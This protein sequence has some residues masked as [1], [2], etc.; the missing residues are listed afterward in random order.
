MKSKISLA[1]FLWF[2]TLTAQAAVAIRNLPDFS[3]L[4]DANGASVVN[5]STTQAVKQAPMPQGAPE[6]PDGSPFND[7][8]RRYFG[9][10]GVPEIDTKSLGSGF[11]I[12]PDGFVLTAAHVVENAKEVVV[13]LTD[14]REFSASVVGA[15]RRSDV[16]LL[17]IAAT[18]LPAVTI[19]DPA[20]LKVGEWV[21]AIGAPFGFESSATSGIVSAKGRSLPTENYVPFIQTDVAINPGNSG[22]PLFNLNGEVVGINSQIYSRTGGFMGLSFAVPIDMAMNIAQQLKTA[23]RVKRGWLGVTIQDVTRELAQSFGM[24][25]PYGALI[26]DILPNSPASKSELRVGDVVV[27]YEGKRIDLSSELPP[28]VG[29]TEAGSRVKLGVMR[30]GQYRTVHVRVGELPDEAATTRPTSTEP[31]TGKNQLGLA[32]NELTPQQKKQLDL[33]HGVVV[34]EIG[35][36]PALHAGIRPG[37]VIVEV[38]GKPIKNIAAFDQALKQAPKDRPVAV[39]VRRG[40]GSLFLALQLAS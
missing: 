19:G 34:A 10:G 27:D 25:T 1:L 7:L 3:A 14:R 35:N 13:K 22:G 21:L 32:I 4:V 6:F 15:D 20:K 9:E 16:A 30:Q 23:G 38:D 36:G 28:K 39:L 18:G 26:S 37:D 5:I 33:E 8:F 24:K 29:L 31:R 40:S 2:F 11:I 17:K 12:S